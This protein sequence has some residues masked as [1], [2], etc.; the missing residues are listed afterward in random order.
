MSEYKAHPENYKGN[1]S[2]VA[3]IL[4]IAVT[5][6]ANSPDLCTIMGILGRERSLV[7]LEKGMIS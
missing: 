2:D 1:V 3:E 7:R 6:S 5:G 4:R